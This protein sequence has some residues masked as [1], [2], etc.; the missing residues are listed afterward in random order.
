MTKS[1]ERIEREQQFHDLRYTEDYKRRQKVSKFY[2]ITDS[3][4]KA[5]QK[6]LLDSSKN[7]KVIE[8]GCGKG[9]CAFKIA[10]NQAKLVTGIDI[11]PVAID[12]AHQQAVREDL[13]DNIE[14]KIMNAE[15]LE[16]EESS[17]DLICGSRIL[18]HLDLALATNSIVKT[19][20]PE[21]KAVFLE[22]LGHNLLINLYRR[23]TPTIRTEDEH[24]L[25]ERDL[26]AI[27][28][29]FKQ[30]KIHYFY[31]TSLVASFIA[32]KP[33]FKILLH[34]CEL[35]D[36]ILLRIPGI[37]QQAWLVL[38]ELEQPIKGN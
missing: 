3:I 14:F 33:G 31:L 29:K 2:S 30:S 38:I 4:T 24:P 8:Y 11:S 28:S 5:Y 21:G 22:P 16:F 27:K 23:L 20:K 36:S 35:I 15:N 18:H 12:I 10:K 9:S 19:L 17:H 25:L 34:C 6:S 26:K 1:S 13:R 32:N 37:R 7:S